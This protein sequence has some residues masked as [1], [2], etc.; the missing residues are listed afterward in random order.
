MRSAIFV[1][2]LGLALAVMATPAQAGVAS[3]VI[4]EAIEFT[5][6]KFGKE[7]AEEGVERMAGKMTQLA[8]KYGDDVVV[9]AFKK[10][11]PRAGT[12]ASEAG[13]H[14]GVA[15]RVLSQHGDEAIGLAVSKTSLRTVARYG[16]DAGTAL[17]RHGTV[18]QALIDGFGKTGVEA[19]AQVTPQNGR[20]MAMLA[21]DG[22][23]KPELM[24]V[25]ARHGDRA[26]DFIWR[27]K[28]AL[29]VGTTLTVFLASP[30]E[31]IEGAADL[32]ATVGDSAVKP[33]ATLPGA[34]ASEAA[35]RVN[36]NLLLLAVAV[37]LGI[38]FSRWARFLT[39]LASVAAWW[40]ARRVNRKEVRRD[41]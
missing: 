4:R 3:K 39:N 24:S 1:S 5:S 34:V 13:E 40:S 20:R 35:K 36:W 31:F 15:L 6:K 9:G 17:V 33:L 37:V 41:A 23:L 12:I 27:N 11:G 19:L 25:I 28:G 18:G 7:V 22:A 26:C 38:A 29:A 32:A 30:E 14:G 2:G 10:V 16:D 8:A 21:T